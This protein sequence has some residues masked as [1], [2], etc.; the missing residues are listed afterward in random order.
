MNQSLTDIHEIIN[1][2]L[3][4]INQPALGENEKIITEKINIDGSERYSSFKEEGALFFMI[5]LNE[6]GVTFHID[7]TDEIP[8]YTYQQIIEN[9]EEFEK[10][11]ETLFT[12]RSRIKYKGNKT[13][14]EFFDQ[15]GKPMYFYILYSGIGFS[16][17][18]RERV[19]DYPPYFS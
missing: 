11:L 6:T 15:E 8:N 3:K 17:F 1:G 7:R 2:V 9:R 14:V 5:E 4:S 10:V 16:L 13:T 12:K 19:F 18:S